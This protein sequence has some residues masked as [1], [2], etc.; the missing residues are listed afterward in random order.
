M[1]TPWIFKTEARRALLYGLMIL[2]AAL[3]PPF[4]MLVNKLT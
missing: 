4:I 3:T 2:I 1:K